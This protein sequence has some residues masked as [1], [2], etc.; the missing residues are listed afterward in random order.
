M[1]VAARTRGRLKTCVGLFFVAM[2]CVG[3]YRQRA[4][5]AADEPPPPQGRGATQTARGRT[6]YVQNCARCHGADGRS[7]T[8]LGELYDATDLTATR[9]WKDEHINDRRL[10]NSIA[11]GKKG[12]MPAFGKRLAKTDIAALV[13]YVRAF[14]R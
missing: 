12:G 1:R 10:T 8:A 7:Q 5:R 2:L 4:A 9:W 11:N 3:G 14:K 13:A 6:L